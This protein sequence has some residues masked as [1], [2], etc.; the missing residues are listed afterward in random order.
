MVEAAPQLIDPHVWVAPRDR[1]RNTLAV[2]RQSG[3]AVPLVLLADTLNLTR[4]GGGR[5]SRSSGCRLVGTGL[6]VS[7]NTTSS[8]VCSSADQ[9]SWSSSTSS[10]SI[11]RTERGTV[12]LSTSGMRAAIQRRTSA[13][14]PNS[15]GVSLCTSCRA[16][17]S[18]SVPECPINRPG[19]VNLSADV[20]Q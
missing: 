15:A 3:R 7:P 17:V 9:R 10:I 6:R 4:G 19:S 2:R 1:Q 5:R 18:P 12:E 8:S 20:A 11:G 14:L 16:T 13:T